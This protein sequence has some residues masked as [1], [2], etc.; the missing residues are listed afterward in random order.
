[1]AGRGAFVGHEKHDESDS[2][3]GLI[4]RTRAGSTML[5]SPFAPVMLICAVTTTM[6]SISRSSRSK[7]CG[8]VSTHGGDAPDAGLTAEYEIEY[9]GAWAV[10][11]G[12]EGRG[13]PTIIEMVG[14]TRLDCVFGSAALMRRAVTEAVHHARHREAFGGRLADSA[15]MQNVLA[16]L[17]IESEAPYYRLNQIL[18]DIDYRERPMTVQERLDEADAVTP[19]TNP[20]KV[21][22]LKKGRRTPV[23]QFAQGLYPSPSATQQ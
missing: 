11:V 7:Q 10:M 16:D 22:R 4:K 15:L 21:N 12:A 6:S 8:I 1:M 23:P 20:G 14:H 3:G 2:P 17:A 18:D 9:A 19:F 5:H 13:V